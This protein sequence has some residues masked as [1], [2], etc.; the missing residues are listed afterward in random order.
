M[1]RA[2]LWHRGLQRILTLREAPLANREFR[3]EMPQ[4]AEGVQYEILYMSAIIT[5]GATAGNRRYN[6]FADNGA[7]RYA[8]WGSPNVEVAL[9]TVEFIAYPGAVLN[10]ILNTIRKGQP[11]P[12][13][14]LRMPAGHGIQSET[15]FVDAAD[16]WNS[17]RV[18]V[19][20]WFYEPPA[21][22]VPNAG[23]GADRVDVV[24]FTDAL[25][26]L[27]SVLR[28]MESAQATP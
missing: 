11:M 27:E 1:L 26:R 5:N 12:M 22:R 14:I 20:E 7:E 24:R 28:L 16:Q 21:E 10:P 18:L 13:P 4:G 23:D 6:F 25:T 2:G 19:Q 9:S 15:D 17:V 3:L 8:R